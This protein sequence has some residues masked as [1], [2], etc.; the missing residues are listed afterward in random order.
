MLFLEG[1][2]RDGCRIRELAGLPTERL[3]DGR[4]IFDAV[5]TKGRKTRRSKVPTELYDELRALA[6]STFVFEKFPDELKALLLKRGTPHHA[7]CVTF[8]FDSNC[9]VG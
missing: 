6:G 9:L 3:K 8:P 1:K 5:T 4:P 2:S 7:N